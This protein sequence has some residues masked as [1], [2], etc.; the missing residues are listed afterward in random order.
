MQLRRIIPAG[1]VLGVG[2]LLVACAETKPVVRQQYDIREESTAIVNLAVVSPDNLFVS[3][4]PSMIDEKNLVYT[5]RQWVD[6]NLPNTASIWRSPSAGGPATKLVPAGD[7]EWLFLA[8]SAPKAANV[9]YTLNGA[10]Y[11]TVKSGAGGRRKYP[12]TGYSDYS[13]IPFPDESRILFASCSMGR[14]CFFQDSNYIWLMNPDGTNMTQ[15]RQGR[16][17]QLSP[18]AKMIVFAYKGD[19]WTMHVDG[20]EATNLTASDD[21]FDAQ[22]TFSTDGQRI[23]FMRKNSK[24][25]HPQ[26]D[27]WMMRVD[28]T[29]VTQLTMN[30]ADDF[31]PYA[32]PDGYV[33]FISNR[34]ALIGNNY[35]QRVWRAQVATGTVSPVPLPPPP[36]PAGGPRGG[37]TGMDGP[38]A[39]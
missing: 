12:G 20:T 7:G 3:N 14:D 2:A 33:Y 22:P 16:D 29:E 25:E 21:Y 36:A 5:A 34:G 32:G 24:A 18:N 37:Q 10:L 8:R 15:L 27:I 30:P 35:P 13:P 39:R 17:A 4:T 31:A 9:Y 1:I 19:I 26:A 28:G 6:G 38:S 11:S 23:F